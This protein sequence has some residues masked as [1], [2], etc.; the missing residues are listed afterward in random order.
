VNARG[1]MPRLPLPHLPVPHLPLFGRRARVRT[2][3]DPL[4]GKDLSAIPVC[5]SVRPSASQR[6]LSG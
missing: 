1:A 3:P 4:R 2:P 6:E 5:G